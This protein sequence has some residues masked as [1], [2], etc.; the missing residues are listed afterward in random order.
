[1]S[2]RVLVVLCRGQIDAFSLLCVSVCDDDDDAADFF[3]LSVSLLTL[4]PYSVPPSSIFLRLLIRL[5][6]V[7]VLLVFSIHSLSI[8][9][10]APLSH[11]HKE[12][13]THIH[14]R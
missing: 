12:T 2:V 13:H 4:M 5:R 3:F 7:S 1:M 11:T 9:V 14:R 8:S 6:P 10:Q